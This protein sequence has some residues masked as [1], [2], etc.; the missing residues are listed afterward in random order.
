ME[1]CTWG[2]HSNNGRKRSRHNNASSSAKNN[3]DSSAAAPPL[4]PFQLLQVRRDATDQEI[5]QRYQRLAVLY[6]PARNPNHDAWFTAVAAAYETLID[7][8]SRNHMCRL[9]SEDRTLLSSN[10]STSTTL[11]DTQHYSREVTEYLFGG[12]LQLMYRARRFE[13]FTDPYVLF[14]QVF[15]SSLGTAHQQQTGEVVVCDI[16]H[17]NKNHHNNNNNTLDEP[18]QRHYREPDGT[19]VSVTTRY[20]GNRCLTRTVR[21]SSQRPTFVSVTSIVEDQRD[22][23]NDTDDTPWF[24]CCTGT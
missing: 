12:P 3:D 10:S 17:R 15:G 20:K 2:L 9:L 5:L 7:E 6:H 4:D 11:D 1:C 21:Q 13:A 22:E 16:V 14:E 8:T 24:L 23:I 18:L 19:N